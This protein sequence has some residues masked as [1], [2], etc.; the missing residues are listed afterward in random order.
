MKAF[1]S[2]LMRLIEIHSSSAVKV[3][4]FWSHHD[5]SLC[6][7]NTPSPFMLK[8]HSTSYVSFMADFSFYSKTGDDCMH[9]AENPSLLNFSWPIFFLT[10][11]DP[12][13]LIPLLFNVP[14][15]HQSLGC[16][17]F[18]MLYILESA[19]RQ[20]ARAGL[21]FTSHSTRSSSSWCVLLC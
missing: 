9:I 2:S 11:S 15:E 8:C 21:Q 6:L 5:N 7:V 13:T 20:E 16:L 10:T 1:L 4:L 12:S 19:S 3:W 18:H 17:Y 14:S